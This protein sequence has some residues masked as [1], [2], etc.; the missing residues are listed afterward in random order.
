MS[1]L[2]VVAFVYG[3]GQGMW[4]SFDSGAGELMMVFE[5][6]LAMASGWEY[7]NCTCCVV[8]KMT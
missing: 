2:I 5:N 3:A 7:H 6:G 4:D 1:F 8:R